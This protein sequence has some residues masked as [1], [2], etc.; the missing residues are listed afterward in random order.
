M[1]DYCIAAVWIINGVYCKVLNLVPRHQEIV[2]RITGTSQPRL[3][4]TLIGVA[5]VF[6]AVW[7]ISGIQR[8]LNAVV[9]MG[10]I[11]IMNILEFFIVP[12]LLLWGRANIIFAFLFVLIIYFNTFRILRQ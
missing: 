2:A 5:E 1:L 3:L 10:V 12:D 11:T 4:T 9:Q 6:M 8:R 7:I